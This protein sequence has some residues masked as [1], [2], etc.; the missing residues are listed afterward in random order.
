MK[1]LHLAKPFPETSSSDD[2]NPIRILRLEMYTLSNETHTF[3]WSERDYKL[4]RVKV[5]Q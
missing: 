3:I 2:V 4:K 1:S 5:A